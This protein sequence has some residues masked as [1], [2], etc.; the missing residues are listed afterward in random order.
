MSVSMAAANVNGI[1]CIYLIRYS[2]NKSFS[3]KF[4]VKLLISRS[5]VEKE[6]QEH[7]DVL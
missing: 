3:H 6:V 4:L 5:E 7:I 1:A 2:G